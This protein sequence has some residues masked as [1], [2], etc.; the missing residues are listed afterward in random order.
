M[1][2]GHDIEPKTRVYDLSREAI[3]SLDTKEMLKKGVYE[4]ATRALMLGQGYTTSGTPP[5][6]DIIY[7]DAGGVADLAFTGLQNPYYYY[8]YARP[9]PFMSGAHFL[10]HSTRFTCLFAD[11]LKLR[12]RVTRESTGQTHVVL[13]TVLYYPGSNYV[14]S[15]YDLLLFVQ[16]D[17][18]YENEWQGNVWGDYTIVAASGV[19]PV[20]QIMAC[21]ICNDVGIGPEFDSM[22]LN[23]PQTAPGIYR[24]II[25]IY[26]LPKELLMRPNSN[27]IEISVQ[28]GT[29][30]IHFSPTRILTGRLTDRNSTLDSYD[31]V[32]DSTH[33]IPSHHVLRVR[34]RGTEAWGVVKG[35]MNFSMRLLPHYASYRAQQD[36]NSDGFVIIDGPVE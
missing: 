2:A 15:G 13:D 12:F 24:I 23:I 32:S 14:L 10:G 21:T 11:D 5:Q 17:M 6:K 1:L 22:D 7:F 35:T 34:L 18:T 33:N 30:E 3:V 20:K 29:E 4:I 19:V 31:L 25:S 26:L 9:E 36:V 27:Q 28:F 8:T 16:F